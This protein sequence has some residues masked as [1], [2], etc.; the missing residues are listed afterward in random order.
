[1]LLQA[2]HMPQPENL[3]Y[4]NKVTEYVTTCGQM[5]MCHL[6]NLY[7]NVIREIVSC[8]HIIFPCSVSVFAF[9]LCSQ[10]YLVFG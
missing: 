4:F 2:V 7:A 8:S 9:S 1:M 3:F 10:N 6:C 5:I